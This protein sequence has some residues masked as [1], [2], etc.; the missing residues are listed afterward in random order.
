RDSVNFVTLPLD[1]AD[2]IFPGTLKRANAARQELLWTLADADEGFAELV[3]ERDQEQ[4]A[5]DDDG[6]GGDGSDLYTLTEI[7]S[8]VRRVCLSRAAVPVLCG[9]SLR[10]IGVEPLLDSVSTFLPSPLDR[11]RPTGVV[12]PEARCTA[13][14]ACRCHRSPCRPSRRSSFPKRF[15]P[16]EKKVTHDKQ[17]GL[18]SFFRVYSG[19]LEAK[20]PVYNATRGAEERPL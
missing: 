9:A 10:G 11:P 17:R 18:L 15:W 1:H 5:G 13:Y 16:M 2:L 8:A 7:L 12:R 4:E 3:L 19:A 14:H 20:V 6:G